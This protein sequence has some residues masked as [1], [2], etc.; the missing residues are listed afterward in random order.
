MALGVVLG[1]VLGVKIDE[2]YQ[3]GS[4]DGL[5]TFVLEME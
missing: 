3:S 5:V 1:V 4:D 2:L